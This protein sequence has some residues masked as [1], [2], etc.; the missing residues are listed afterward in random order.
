MKSSKQEDEIYSN[1]FV[2][3]EEKLG[4]R[5]E[6]FFRYSNDP[7]LSIQL[8]FLGFHRLIMKDHYEYPA[9]R[10]TSFELILVTNGPYKCSLNGKELQVGAGQVLLIQPGD[11][12]QDHLHS[13]QMHYVVHFSLHWAGQTEPWIQQIFSTPADPVHRIAPGPFGQEIDFLETIGTE[14][15]ESEWLAGNIQDALLNVIFWRVVRQFPISSL[16]KQFVDQLLNASFVDR[17]FSEIERC[18]YQHASVNEIARNMNLSTR[19][20]AHKVAQVTGYPP[21]HWLRHAKVEAGKNLM[22]QQHLNVKEAAY[23]LG[24]KN[25]FH[26]SQTFK[27]LTGTSPSDWAKERS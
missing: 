8:R 20:L 24:F 19:T 22:L 15:S 2:Q 10:H 9:H 27:A 12:H 7:T 26:F 11:I 17:F 5:K 1:P 23:R 6:R 13:G 4:M 18:I 3:T 14:A 21:V 16:Q 25:P